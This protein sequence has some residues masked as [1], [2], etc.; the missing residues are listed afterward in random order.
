MAWLAGSTTL[1]EMAI[2]VAVVDR[3]SF[4]LGAVPAEVLVGERFPGGISCTE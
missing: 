2:D 1:S 4:A 3:P